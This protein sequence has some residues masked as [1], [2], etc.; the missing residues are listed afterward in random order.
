M[1]D[2]VSENSK[3]QAEYYDDLRKETLDFKVEFINLQKETMELNKSMRE[4][5]TDLKNQ[6]IKSE[7]ERAE[8]DEQMRELT[9]AI[10]NLNKNDN[11]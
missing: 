7:T 8:R 5:L 6:L 4:E 11:K 2:A 1:L 9:S 3:L 10:K